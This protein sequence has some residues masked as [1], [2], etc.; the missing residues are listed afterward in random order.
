M[1]TGS[2]PRVPIALPADSGHT[3]EG[4]AFLQSRLVLFGG[5]TFLI[6]GG[7]LALGLLMAVGYGLAFRPSAFFHLV[8]ALIPGSLWAIGRA[9]PL[10]VGMARSLD[11]GG[12]VLTCASFAAMAGT[13]AR[14]GYAF[15]AA[16]DGFPDTVDPMH[17]LS[18]GL[19]ACSYVL[20]SRAIAVPSTPG[21][22]AWISAMGVLPLLATTTYVFSDGTASGPVVTMAHVDIV[23]WS[24]AAVAMS[25]VA[26]RVIFGLRTEMARI[27]Q[28]GQ[29]TLEDKIGEGGMGVVYRARHALLRRPTAIKLLPP[30][31]AGEEN[32]RRFEREVQMT[33]GLSHPSTVAIFDY[34]R[35]PE[36]VFYYAMEYLDGIDLDR[37]VREHGPQPPARVIRI[38][39]QVCG[40][41]AEAHGIG[42]IHRD[43]KPANIILC[44]RGGEPDVAKVVDFGLVKRIDA[45]DEEAT[46][47]VTAGI[48]LLGTPLYIAPETISGRDDADGRADLYALGAVGYYLL[49]GTPVFTGKTV[50]EVLA[51]HLHTRPQPPSARTASTIPGDLEHLVLECLAKSPDDRPRD[52]RSLELELSVCAARTPWPRDQAA[53]W[54]AAFRQ[55]HPSAH[56]HAVP[57]PMRVTSIS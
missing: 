48:A 28:A 47:V 44:E 39:H 37:L 5:W 17:A 29:Y 49:T 8:G 53:A 43:V 32:V 6:A 24:A 31:K 1:S 50:V 27:R 22:T 19:L 54:W 30:E 42:L 35:T 26:S 46:Q 45:I 7:F 25:A 3:E 11:A 51:H 15:V 52:A 13:I 9:R 23:S 20:F 56:H 57:E 36:G 2:R 55:A 21:R 41:L 33:A 14:S 34:G 18:I 38:L 16:D 4:R 12:T 10:S 40:A